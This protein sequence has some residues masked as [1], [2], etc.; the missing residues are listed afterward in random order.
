MPL[1]FQQTTRGQK[2]AEELKEAI[3]VTANN[4]PQDYS[5]EAKA[6]RDSRARH[7]MLYGAPPT[8]SAATEYT[9][10]NPR[11]SSSKFSF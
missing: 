11:A 6:K 2:N 5:T 9:Q 1:F 4:Y 10:T 8:L 7:R 3:V